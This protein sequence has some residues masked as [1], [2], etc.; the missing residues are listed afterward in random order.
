MTVEDAARAAVTAELDELR[1]RFGGFA[2]EETRV[3]NDPD[4]YEHGL[5]L[6][7]ETGM[8][9]DA[10]ALVRDRRNRLLLIRHPD[11]PETW[12]TPGGGY[13]AGD[14]S[15]VETA[16]REVSEETGVHCSVTAVCAA[17][18]KTIDHRD[19]SRSFPMLT[20]EFAADGNGVVSAAEDDEVLEARWFEENEVRASKITDFVTEQISTEENP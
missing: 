20:V 19:D 7:R 13:E 15:L 1:E 6:V 5:E 3:E 9:A 10:G 18:V 17:R 2:V 11:A 14:D 4:F 16:V 12:G 8:L